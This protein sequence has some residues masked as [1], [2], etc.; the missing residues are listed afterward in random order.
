MGVTDFSQIPKRILTYI[1]LRIEQQ[2]FLMSFTQMMWY[3]LF[4]YML[5]L[6]PLYYLKLDK[7]RQQSS[8]PESH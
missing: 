4:A 2:V 7:P 5:S 8:V 3:I 1:Q 6:I